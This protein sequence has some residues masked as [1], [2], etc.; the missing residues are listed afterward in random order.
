MI[1]PEEID[2]PPT[3]STMYL[4]TSAKEM[5]LTSADGTAVGAKISL[6]DLG[7]AISDS[8]NDGLVTV[9]TE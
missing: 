4:D 9:I 5:Y 6:I 8:S 3:V 7:N 1:T 2:T